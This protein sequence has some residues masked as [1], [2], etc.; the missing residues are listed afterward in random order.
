MKHGSEF[1]QAAEIT[2]CEMQKLAAHVRTP[3][4]I[5]GL[6]TLIQVCSCPNYSYI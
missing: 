4:K 2:D 3:D 5:F 1:L 6:L